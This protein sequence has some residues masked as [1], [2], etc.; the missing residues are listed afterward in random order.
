VMWMESGEIN[1]YIR[2]VLLGGMA[3]SVATL[4]LGLAMFALS[5][6]SWEPVTLSLGEIV[7]GLAQ[8][9]P[10]AVIDLGIIMLIVT[11]FSRVLAATVLFAVNRENRFVY[12]GL[13]IIAVIGLA[14]LIGA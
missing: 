2:S 8:G 1:R 4:T 11:P 12:V 7:A 14:I 6:G 3:L 13:A 9:N 5:D 10:I